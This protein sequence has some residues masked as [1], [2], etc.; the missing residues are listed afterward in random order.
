MSRGTRLSYATKLQRLEANLV[1]FDEKLKSTQDSIKQTKLEIKNLKL[2]EV[3][4]IS[5]DETLTNEQKIVQ[6]A[7]IG[8]I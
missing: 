1:D 2:T 5:Q 7:A 6:I 4:R 8:S 3:H